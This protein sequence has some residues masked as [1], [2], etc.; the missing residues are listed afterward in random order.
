[1]K[2]IG[3]WL[4]LPLVALSPAS[5]QVTVEV[6]QDQDQ[7]LPGE[8]IIT[9]ARITNRSGQTLRL[10]AEDN[11]LT[12]SVESGDR[13]VVPKSGDAPV[14]GEFLLPSSKVATKRVDLAPYFSASIPGRYSVV[15]T[16][17]IKDWD[18]EVSS[19]PRKFD[20]IEG[21]K[22]WEQEIGVP[23]SASATNSTPEVRKYILQQAH[24]LKTQ[25][26][27][28][29]RL[30]DASGAKVFRVRAIGPTVSFGQPEPQVDKFSNLHVLYQ[31]RP[32]SFNYTVFNP[33]GDVLLR[34]TYDY[35]D[36]RP[37]L[38]PDGQGKISVAGGSRRVTPN[39]WP[40]PKPEALS[41]DGPKPPI[42]LSET[43]PPKR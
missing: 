10:G 12:F 14:T 36:T 6:T 34:Q 31:D 8:A 41:D 4:C 1:M 26:R 39:D 24:Y 23:G 35:M 38:Q 11:W 43:N 9:A 21:A 3:L 40:A 5:A 18:R 20:V 7:F 33:D 29:L 30:T 15:A 27:L 19:P 32:H 25:L 42:P 22:L 37:R 2:Q 13:G 28:Y 16:V 17:R